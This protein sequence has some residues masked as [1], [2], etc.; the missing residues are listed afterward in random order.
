MNTLYRWAFKYPEPKSIPLS[1]ENDREK[2]I[3]IVDMVNSCIG[4][5]FEKDVAAFK[6]LHGHEPT[7][8][9][10]QS[11]HPPIENYDPLRKQIL[12]ECLIRC[13]QIEI[14]EKY[15]LTSHLDF[16]LVV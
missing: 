6:V 12:L 4:K 5:E 7:D 15:K 8:S 10:R 3:E 9:E 1:L 14:D 11:I 13:L 2:I 16:G